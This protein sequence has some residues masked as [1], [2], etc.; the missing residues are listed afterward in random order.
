MRLAFNLRSRDARFTVG[1]S[2]RL[3]I[4]DD[5]VTHRAFPHHVLPSQPKPP[6][7][8]VGVVGATPQ[9][10]VVDNRRAAVREGDDMVVLEE[11]ALGAATGRS[12]K[13]AATAVP[14]PDC[15]LH[16]RRDVPALRRS[17]RRRPGPVHGPVLRPVQLCE[18]QR[19]RPIDNG[20]DVAFRY[21]VPKQI[22]SFAE[23]VIRIT[24]LGGHPKPAIDGHLKTGH[25]A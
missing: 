4:A 1:A 6:L 3:P 5:L 15:A 11:P 8:L 25:H 9:L 23:L 12:D 17:L 13:G 20:T 19:Q 10:E 7:R 24:R 16:R 21:P 14:V 18:E 2:A 22:L